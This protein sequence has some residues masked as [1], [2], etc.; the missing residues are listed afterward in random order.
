[1]TTATKRTAKD[2]AKIAAATVVAGAAVVGSAIGLKTLW[3]KLPDLKEAVKPAVEKEAPKELL[4]K[5]VTK[6]EAPARP[7]AERHHDLKRLIDDYAGRIYPQWYRGMSNVTEEIQQISKD[8]EGTGEVYSTELKENPITHKDREIAREWAAVQHMLDHGG[9]VDPQNK[10]K[11]YSPEDWNNVLRGEKKQTEIFAA[12]LIAKELWTLRD[13]DNAMR[14]GTPRDRY[15]PPRETFTRE[16]L[17]KHGLLPGEKPAAPKTDVKPDIPVE[18][19]EKIDEKVTPPIEKIKPPKVSEDGAVMQLEKEKVWT[20][21][22]R[23]PRD[24]PSGK[25]LTRTFPHMLKLPNG[26]AGGVDEYKIV[27]DKIQAT[28]HHI[29]VNADG[30]VRLRRVTERFNAEDVEIDPQGVEKRERPVEV[31]KSIEDEIKRIEAEGALKRAEI[32]YKQIGREP[33][34]RR[35]QQESLERRQRMKYRRY[36][37]PRWYR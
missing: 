27:G 23:I 16:I 18:A 21:I 7:L 28:S 30:T 4:P 24:T 8:H 29:V 15:K 35:A 33:L 37:Q 12:A 32:G 34:I 6:A 26:L 9:R 1:M 25:Y 20:Q 11:W 19:V 13:F 2:I 10:P 36:W 31:V 17:V 22:G 5:P 3:K 14:S